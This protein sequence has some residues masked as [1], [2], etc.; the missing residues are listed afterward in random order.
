[1]MPEEVHI[2]VQYLKLANVSMSFYCQ[3]EMETQTHN[4]CLYILLYNKSSIPSSFGIIV[5]CMLVREIEA[6]TGFHYKPF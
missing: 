6:L 5:R 2:T 1:M 4:Q 3:T